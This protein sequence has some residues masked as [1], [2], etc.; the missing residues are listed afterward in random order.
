V[1][2]YPDFTEFPGN[3][4]EKVKTRLRTG[5]GPT[6]VGRRA[7]IVSLTTGKRMKGTAHEPCNRKSEIDGSIEAVRLLLR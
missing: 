5:T 3:V 6:L 2:H 1:V 7:N 4:V